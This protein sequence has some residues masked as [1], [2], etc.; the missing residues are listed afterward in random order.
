MS[1]PALLLVILAGIGIGYLLLAAVFVRRLSRLPPP[2]ESAAESV[3]ILKPLHGEEPELAENLTSFLLQDYPAEVQVVFGVQ[4]PADPAIAVVRDLQAAFPDRDVTLVID[5]RAHGTNRKVSNLV[6]MAAHARHDVIVL[7]DS[8]MRVPPSY[9]RRVVA[10]LGAPGVGAVTCP[11]HGLSIGT[12]WSRLTVLGIDRHF[13]P[14]IATGVG[15]GIGH[16]CMGST[17]A[18]RR[19]T[20]ERIG[21]FDSVADELADDHVIGARVRGLGLA[22]PVAAFTVGHL[23]PERH[24]RD[25]LRQELRWMRT[26]RQVEPAGHFGSLVT[27]PF[28]FALA[29]LLIEPGLAT[30]AALLLSAGA[31][32]ALCLAVERAFGL[33]RHPYWL[34]PMRDLLSFALFAASFFGRAVQWR[35]HDYG[36]ARSGV[37]LPK[38]T[39]E[40][41]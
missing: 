37:L 31:G 6:N 8:D 23:C 9:L 20:L 38:M 32:F 35:G 30:G 17:I 39:R 13:L 25:L 7:A 24:L 21:G 33:K 28:P 3:T 41:T 14:G 11:Y 26:V 27:H 12:L 34:L 10:M 40:P 15:L 36:V 5:G 29:A 18:I 22:V 1:L 16:P 4:H 19:E 2:E